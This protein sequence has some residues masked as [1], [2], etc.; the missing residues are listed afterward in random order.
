MPLLEVLPLRAGPLIDKDLLLHYIAHTAN[1]ARLPSQDG[2]G[3]IVLF[4]SAGYLNPWQSLI[5]IE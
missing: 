2:I 1:R 3:E 4:A 5:P